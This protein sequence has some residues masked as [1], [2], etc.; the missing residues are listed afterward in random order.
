MADDNK[1][2]LL[3]SVRQA[4]VQRKMARAERQHLITGE[5]DENRINRLPPG[6]RQVENW[7]VLDLGVQPSIDPASWSSRIDGFVLNSQELD[8]AALKA[9]PVH[10]QVCDMHCV[11]AWS[12]FDNRFTGVSTKTLLD[13][14]QPLPSAQ[15]V[16][17]HGADG[18]T[19]N[20]SLE[21]FS[22]PDAML[23]YAHD[24]QPITRDHGGPV[25]M[26][27]PQWYLWKSAKWITRIEF[28]DVD[29]PGFWEVRGYHNEGD[30][31]GEERYS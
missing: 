18:Y 2:G 20:V 14:V 21:A 26:L 3:G 17:F 31:W 13:A 5:A 12:R 10:E 4:F 15:H 7:P 9:L 27:L 24:G 11:T 25:R 16:I 6:Q 30:P 22:A 28:S 1:T 19:T 8:F 29:K 23:A